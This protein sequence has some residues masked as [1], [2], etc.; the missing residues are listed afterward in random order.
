MLSIPEEWR[1]I[2]ISLPRQR[3]LVEEGTEDNDLDKITEGVFIK[4][5]GYTK[6]VGTA[7]MLDVKYTPER[8]AK[9]TRA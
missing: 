6:Q 5:V 3:F 7:S 1:Q 2:Q 4:P 9:G 8:L